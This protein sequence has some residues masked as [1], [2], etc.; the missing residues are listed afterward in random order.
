V[1]SEGYVEVKG[2][3]EVRRLD[4]LVMRAARI[5]DLSKW[6]SGIT[7]SF[8]V[9]GTARLKA[10]EIENLEKD[11]SPHQDHPLVKQIGKLMRDLGLVTEKPD[12]DAFK[13]LFVEK[14]AVKSKPKIVF[15]LGA[16]SS[17]PPPSNIPTI[18][19]MLGVIVSK[20]PPSENPMTNKIKEWSSRK[21]VTIEDIMTAGYL[22]SQFVSNMTLNRLVGEIV[23]RTPTRRELERIPTRLPQLRDVEYVV[24]FKDLVDRI[25]SIISGI[26]IKADSNAVHDSVA[27]LVKHVG[28][29]FDFYLLTTN[30]DICI[31]KA[32]HKE[33]LIPTYLGIEES[34]GVPLVKIHG[35]INWFYC[36]G[37]QD[38][39]FFSIEE[40]GKFDKVYPTTASCLKCNTLTQLFMVPP[41]A[42][43]YVTYP[44]IVEIWQSAMKILEEADLIVVVGYSFSLSDDYLLKMIVNGL[45]KKL[46]PLVFLTNSRRVV[47]ELESRLLSYH[48]GVSLSLVEDASVSMPKVCKIIE[49]SASEKQKKLDEPSLTGQPSSS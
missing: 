26:M 31:E 10:E 15:L 36:E 38:V 19:E 35:S 2:M 16:G 22:S 25:F 43:K 9:D 45:K 3:D 28:K 17:K 21:D 27:K 5:F 39:V 8:N 13:S 1:S 4:D 42:Y 41:L 12:Y 24:S 32:L 46:S 30:Y 18:A 7:A 11:L 6:F 23:Y 29:D 20:L 49:D 40:L 47:K 34:D 37:C 33:S 14:V 44:P 48:E